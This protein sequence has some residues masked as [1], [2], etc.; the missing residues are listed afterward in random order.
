MRLRLKAARHLE[1]RAHARAT[2]GVRK[3][4]AGVYACLN[5]RICML[6]AASS[7]HAHRATVRRRSGLHAACASTHVGGGAACA[8]T[9]AGHLT[10]A[11]P[12]Y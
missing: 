5:I 11:K 9:P 6:H 8:A 10:A 12:I 2:L 7:A 4:R 3:G 1:Q